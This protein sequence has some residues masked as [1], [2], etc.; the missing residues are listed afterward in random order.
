MRKA[1]VVTGLLAVVLLAGCSTS[2][3]PTSASTP[4]TT[5]TVLDEP[6]VEESPAMP[7]PCALV[8]PDQAAAAL[9]EPVEA[10]VDM[11]GGLPGQK[12]CGYNAIDSAA[13]VNVSV[14]PG[15]AE[16]WSQFKAAS[17]NAEPVS[18]VGDEAFRDAGLLQVRQGDLILSVFITGKGSGSNLTPALSDLAKAALAQIG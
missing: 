1:P 18:G 17:P 5:D 8:T 16:L 15:T 3:S 10:G 4:E 11:P 2:G 7:E 14:I 12:S 9:G 13:A 6:V